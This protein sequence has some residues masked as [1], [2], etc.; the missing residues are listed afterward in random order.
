MEKTDALLR[1]MDRTRGYLHIAEALR[2]EIRKMDIP[3]GSRLP[4]EREL[5]QLLDKPVQAWP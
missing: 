4:S 1:P 5:A 3:A 2:Q